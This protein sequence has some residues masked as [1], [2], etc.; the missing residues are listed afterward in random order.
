MRTILIVVL[1]AIVPAI[2]AGEEPEPVVLFDFNAGDAGDHFRRRAIGVAEFRVDDGATASGGGAIR[3]VGYGRRGSVERVVEVRD[4]RRFR[5]LTFFA[6]LPGEDPIEMRIRAKSGRGRAAMLCRVRIEPGPWREIDLPLA[7]WREDT[8]DQ[9]G[10]FAHVESIEIQLDDG[11]GALEIDDFRLWPGDR[12]ERSCRPTEQDWL[13]LVFPDGGGKAYESEHYLLLTN[14]PRGGKSKARK[15]LARL[16][17]AF[18]MLTDRFS[19]P[20][21]TWD[22]SPVFYFATKEEY[23]AFFVRLG[24]HYRVGISAPTAAGYSC[25]GVGA[26]YYDR[27]YGWDRPAFTHEAVHAAVHRRLGLASNGS[28]VQ[29]ALASAVQVGLYPTAVDRGKLKSDLADFVAGK[30]GRFV[31]LGEVLLAPRASLRSYTQLCGFLEFLRDKHPDAL[32]E[33]WVAIRESTE[34]IRTSA[35]DAVLETLDL[36]MPD[37]NDGFLKWCAT[38]KP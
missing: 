3:L 38:W 19:V 31:P 30:D 15:L 10:D 7:A 24:E 1:L 27:K 32:P 12:G 6:R 4:W 28:W 11:K 35:A 5:A 13:A 17:Q 2:A 25:L 36:D 29:E 34:P 18:A 8:Y 9:V 22:P 26:S 14:A 23:R 33:I 37:L 21:E 16:E 20:P